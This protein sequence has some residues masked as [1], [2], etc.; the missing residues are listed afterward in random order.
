MGIGSVEPCFVPVLALI[1]PQGFVARRV[2][3]PGSVAAVE[4]L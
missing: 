2:D 3:M 4:S 1:P